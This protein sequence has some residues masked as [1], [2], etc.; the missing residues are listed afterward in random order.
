M[1]KR[2]G[3]ITYSLAVKKGKNYK[4]IPKRTL[5]SKKKIPQ[6]YIVKKKNGKIVSARKL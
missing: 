1:A 2:K 4:R 6:T 5:N 3:R